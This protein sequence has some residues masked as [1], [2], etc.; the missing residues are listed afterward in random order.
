M[1]KC[2]KAGLFKGFSGPGCLYRSSEDP[3]TAKDF[4]RFRGSRNSG[5]KD[6]RTLEALNRETL[7]KDILTMV[8][9]LRIALDSK[10]RN[11]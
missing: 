5:N 4:T 9:S 7:G 1:L 2:A 6:S 3:E 8:G 11:L 10:M